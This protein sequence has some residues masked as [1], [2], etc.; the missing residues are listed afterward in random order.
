LVRVIAD[1]HSEEDCAGEDSLPLPGVDLRFWK[2]AFEN[3]LVFDLLV[4][5]VLKQ[6][7][8]ILVW[9]PLCRLAIDPLS[10]FLNPDGKL[11]NLSTLKDS[12]GSPP[13]LPVVFWLE[14]YSSPAVPSNHNS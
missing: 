11:I 13:F 6:T 9:N 2:H 5:K 10:V 14:L 7:A 8:R 12:H 4:G 1:K 3:P